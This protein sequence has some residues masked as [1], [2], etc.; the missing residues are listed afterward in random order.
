MKI[1][2]DLPNLAQI[3][4]IKLDEKPFCSRLLFSATLHRNSFWFIKRKIIVPYQ[5]GLNRINES[6]TGLY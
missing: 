3:A 6:S 2:I 1:R 4:C 5:P